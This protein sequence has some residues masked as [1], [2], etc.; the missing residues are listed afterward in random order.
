[1]TPSISGSSPGPVDAPLWL[2]WILFTTFVV[3]AMIGIGVVLWTLL[4]SLKCR[5][6]ADCPHSKDRPRRGAP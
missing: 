6:D 5:H 4:L 2:Q 1:M 3:P